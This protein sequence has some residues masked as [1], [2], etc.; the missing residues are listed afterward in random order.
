MLVKDISKRS[1]KSDRGGW[2][3]AKFATRD[4]PFY[5]LLASA[6]WVCSPE[7]TKYGLKRS[8]YTIFQ[9]NSVDHPDVGRK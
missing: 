6:V 8:Y 3:G 9:A 1:H 7:L 5:L 2:G 4:P